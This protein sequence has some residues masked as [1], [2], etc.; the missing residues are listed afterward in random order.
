[1]DDIVRVSEVKPLA[2]ESN[3]IRNLEYSITGEFW[4][5][6]MDGVLKMYAT[7]NNALRNTISMEIDR[8]TYFQ[9]NTLLHTHNSS[10]LYMSFYDNRY[11][12]K[13]DGCEP[14]KNLSVNSSTDAIMTVGTT[15]ANLWDVRYQNPTNTIY[16]GGRLGSMGH[17]EY[18]LVDNN[19]IY[20]FDV[21]NDKGPINIKKIPSNFYKGV[22]YSI[23]GQ[24]IVLQASREM[25]FLNSTG[26]FMSRVSTESN[27]TGDFDNDSSQYIYV[28]SSNLVGYHIQNK[29]RAF[30]S[31][32][33]GTEKFTSLRMNPVDRSCIL[34]TSDN[35]V[36]IVYK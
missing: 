8:M 20:L 10:L 17:D 29:S 9:D 30:S 5:Y 32:L 19:L 13:F 16:S 12:A 18:C 31:T 23:D 28:T 3:R 27:W 34:S 35:Q 36:V 2:K 6:T 22:K 11:M 15:N 1:M 25:V 4:S 21:R 24:T 14:I 26:E 7:K 33:S